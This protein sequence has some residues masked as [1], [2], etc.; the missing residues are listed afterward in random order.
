MNMKEKFHAKRILAIIGIVL[1]LGIYAV[2]LIL[3]LIKSPATQNFLNAA[4][5]ATLIIPITLY[6]ILMFIKLSKPTIIEEEKVFADEENDP[7][8]EEDFKE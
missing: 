2:A 3:A 8:T 4:F 1:L 6:F 7:Y 5:A